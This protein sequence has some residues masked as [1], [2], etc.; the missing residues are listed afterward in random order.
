MELQGVRCLFATSLVTSQAN[1]TRVHVTK[2]TTLKT[3]A[4]LALALGLQLEVGLGPQRLQS[5]AAQAEEED[6][7]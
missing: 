1:V 4:M 2:S 3:M 7:R 5:A 6:A